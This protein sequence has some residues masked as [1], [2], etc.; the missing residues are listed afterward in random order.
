MQ[1][2]V[3]KR[4]EIQ[5]NQQ[6]NG[7]IKMYFRVTRG[8]RDSAEYQTTGFGKLLECRRKESKD[9]NYDDKIID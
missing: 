3:F 4:Q 9:E 1:M 5:G 2:S 8:V 6:H 7:R